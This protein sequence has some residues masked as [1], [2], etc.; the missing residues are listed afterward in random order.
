MI[1]TQKDTVIPQVGPQ[2]VKSLQ[3]NI[4]VLCFEKV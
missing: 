3:V 4:D 1:M 2:A